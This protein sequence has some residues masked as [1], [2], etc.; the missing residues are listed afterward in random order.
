MF[1]HI[2]RHSSTRGK[3]MPAE[4]TAPHYI[5]QQIGRSREIIEKA[6]KKQFMDIYESRKGYIRRL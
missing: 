4:I 2:R 6:A 5:T 3:K 1:R